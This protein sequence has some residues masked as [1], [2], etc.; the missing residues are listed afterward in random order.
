MPKQKTIKPKKNV[1][2]KTKELDDYNHSRPHQLDFYEL[3]APDEQHY[4]NTIELYDA[5]PKYIYRSPK[6]DK[7][8]NLKP[9]IRDFFHK[10]EEFTVTIQ[11]ASIQ[12]KNGDFIDIFPKEREELIEDALR[13]LASTGRGV[14]LDDNAS[15]KFTLYQLQQELKR[16]GHS[17]NL[18]QIKEAITVCNKAHMEIKT[19]NGKSILGSTYFPII[20][21]T[22]KDDWKVLGKKTMAYITFNPLVTDSIKQRSFRLLNYDKSMSYRRM[23]ARWLHKR[24]SH[25]YTQAS[26]KDP[27]TIKLLTIIRDSGVNKYP[28]LRNNLVQVN[29]ALEEMKEKQ[30]IVRFLSEKILEGRKII[31]VKFTLW[32]HPEFISEVIKSNKRKGRSSPEELAA[33][34]KM[35]RIN[36]PEK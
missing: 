21:L 17:Y 4:S 19:D 22:T 7:G 6:R 30:I 16:M 11:P 24:L 13:K 12:Q 20:G 15:V 28:A 1:V 25:N 29:E 36:P 33:F 23:L 26:L 31:D 10:G 18:S 34:Y 8:G 2:A 14:F 32:P 3:T 5:V 35:N 9:V 27:Y